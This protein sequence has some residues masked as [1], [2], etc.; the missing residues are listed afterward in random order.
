METTSNIYEFESFRLDPDRKCLWQSGS[1]VSL[2]PKAFETL[3][4]LVRNSG[5]VVGKGESL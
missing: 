2:T 4:V 1:L 3:W 5:E